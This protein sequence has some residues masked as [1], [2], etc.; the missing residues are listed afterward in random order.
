MRLITAPEASLVNKAEGFGTTKSKCFD[1]SSAYLS[2]KVICAAGY[3]YTE[4]FLAMNADQSSRNSL[5]TEKSQTSKVVKTNIDNN[6]LS[7]LGTGVL[8]I[9]HY[10]E[11]VFGF[12]KSRF[13]RSFE[14][15]AFGQ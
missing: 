8:V 15:F 4:T 1:L 10:F 7:F 6:G 14:A 11:Q 13:N 2:S 5:V 12:R 9:K 3:C